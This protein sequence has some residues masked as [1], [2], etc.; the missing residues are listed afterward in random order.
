MALVANPCARW[1]AVN[2]RTLIRP[3]ADSSLPKQVRRQVASASSAAWGHTHTYTHLQPFRS[4]VHIQG[5]R[6]D[7]YVAMALFF[8]APVSVI[9]ILFV[10]VMC[11][12]AWFMEE[13]RDIHESWTPLLTRKLKAFER[14]VTSYYETNENKTQLAWGW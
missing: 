7:A 8:Y 1:T 13:H 14:V 5:S 9:Y 10:F 12:M 11:I 4:L 6:L 3:A 2:E